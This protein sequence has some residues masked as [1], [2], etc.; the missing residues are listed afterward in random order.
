M[1][2]IS[3]TATSPPP[4]INPAVPGSTGGL[5]AEEWT[6][7]PTS[8]LPSFLECLMM[9]EARRS[10]WQSLRSI[11]DVFVDQT[12]RLVVEDQHRFRN[13]NSTALSELLRW[14]PVRHVTVLLRRFIKRYGPEIRLICFYLAERISL[15]YS[16]ATISESLYGG[17]RVKLQ[18]SEGRKRRLLPLSKNDSIRLAFLVTFGPYL[19][20]R[21]N[22]FFRCI[23]RLL[24]SSTARISKLRRIIHTIWPFLQM[25]TKGTFLWYRWRYL[26]GRS[27]FFDP[28]SKVL[29]LIVRR[30]TIEDK[31]HHST[32]STTTESVNRFGACKSIGEA[33]GSILDLIRSRGLRAGVGITSSLA[34]LIMVGRIRSLRNK[35]RQERELK[36]IRQQQQQHDQKNED[37][38]REDRD[39]PLFGGELHDKMLPPPPIPIPSANITQKARVPSNVCSLCNE[40][41][42]HPTALSM[43]YV[44]CLKCLRESKKYSESRLIRLYE[45]ART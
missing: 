22:S 10:G 16:N 40:P 15:H 20:E 37:R 9:E 6:I 18:N 31:Q 29:N 2:N 1:E 12:S 45:P 39:Y 41:R 38:E 36:E 27:I 43:G 26:L 21:S 34:A 5:L 44:F 25:V 42:I 19:Q 11:M 30:V 32:T 24:S 23:L 4:R 14:W 13:S 33:G 17:K 3:S 35:I 8:T 7:D 28:Y